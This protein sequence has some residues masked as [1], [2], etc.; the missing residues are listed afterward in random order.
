MTIILDGTNGVT[1]PV[2]LS[3]ANGGI[4]NSGPPVFS[5]S[6]SATTITPNNGAWTKLTLDTKLFDT[7]TAYSTSTGKFNPQL[8]GY[9]QINFRISAEASSTINRLLASVWKNG[10]ESNRSTDIGALFAVS[11]SALI[12]MN[13]TT[14]YL[15]LYAFV[16]G[17]GLLITGGSN[18]T[19][20]HGFLARAA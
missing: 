11:G 15:E 4:G 8:A 14:D 18:E 20:L 13:G 9:Y 1:L 12:Y 6:Q 16:G 5:V 3:I 7:A 10:A 2:P 17:T 19:F